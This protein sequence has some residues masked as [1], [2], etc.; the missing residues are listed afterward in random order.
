MAQHDYVIA[1]GT[2]AAV[3]SDL[4]N[5]LAAIV[6]QNSGATEPA[7]TYAYQ[8]WAD[9][10]TATL[11]LRNSA[12]SAWIELMQLD[13]TLTMEDGTA[14]LPGL[15]FRDDLDTGI[16]RA[17]TNQFAIS[18]AGV[19]RVE[20]G[21]SEVVFNDS[22]ANYDFR[23]EGDTNAN[24]FFVD[25]SADAVGIGTSSPVRRL[26]IA[27]AGGDP[28]LRLQ[29]TSATESIWT[30][31]DFNG[32]T[33]RQAFIGKAGSSDLLIVNDNLSGALRFS[34]NATERLRIDSSGRVGIGTTSPSQ[35]LQV[36]GAIVATGAATTYSA[37]GI[38]LQN[39]GSSI[40]DIS[41]WRSGA[42]ASVLTFSTESGSDASPIERFRCDSSGRLLVGTS[43][44]PTFRITNNDRTDSTHITTKSGTDLGASFAV[45]Q[46]AGNT[47]STFG[48]DVVFAKSFNGTV[49]THAIGSSG[50]LVSRLFF[51]ASDG[52]RFVPAA[53]IETYIDAAPGSLDMPGRLV[54]STTADGASSPTE[55]LR[56]ANNGAWGLAGANYG[57]SGQV[58]KSNGSASAPTWQND[59][60]GI[61]SAT[62]VA[63]TSGTSIDFTGIPSG[64]KQVTVM[65]NGVSTNG[66]SAMQV[67]L[68]TSSGLL[69]SG[70]LGS[71]QGPFDGSPGAAAHSSGFRLVNP[72]QASNVHHG[73]MI[74]NNISGNVWV[75]GSLISWSSSSGA[76]Y[77]S[78]TVS[79]SATLDRI[80][81]TTNNGTDTFDA[82]SINIMYES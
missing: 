65:L 58:L 27:V 8:F 1:N 44:V 25:A 4:N 66:S 19:E 9:T 31:I 76:G 5:A 21:S 49:G 57:T 14:A 64:V 69:T 41:A 48:N 42:S 37:D 46:W 73:I 53:S 63:S 26:H 29:D 74:I 78:G 10:T 6:S 36:A 38:Y 72:M 13:G 52:T 70:Y 23:V 20:F 35:A 15:A 32:D 45:V 56:I 47:A 71:V 60:G 77:G 7:T 18:S 54:F 81:I 11:K 22:G 40:F 61:T 80:R 2:G 3:R 50:D 67:Q 34:T 62:A 55:R 43:S 30:G 79:L 24:L 16:F 12:N 28:Q 82:G 75:E 39:K 33:N 59:S 68:G 17:G 51:S